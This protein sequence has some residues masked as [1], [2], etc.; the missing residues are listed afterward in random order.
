MKRPGWIVCISALVVVI[1]CTDMTPRQQ[2]TVSGAAI[3]AAGGAG[4][5]AIAGGNAWTGAIIGGAAGAV[6]GNIHGGHQ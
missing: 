5:A 6:A 2:G 3:G 1:G 4:I